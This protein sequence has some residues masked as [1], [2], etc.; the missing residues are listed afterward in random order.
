LTRVPA[1]TLDT[2]ARVFQALYLDIDLPGWG[3]I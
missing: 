1:F 2:T 3:M